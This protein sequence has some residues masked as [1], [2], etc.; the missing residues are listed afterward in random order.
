M[1]A[2]RLR[3]GHLKSVYGDTFTGGYGWAADA[4]RAKIPELKRKSITFNH[5]EQAAEQGHMRSYYRFASHYIHPTSKGLHYEIGLIRQGEVFL[6]GPSNY[7]LAEPANA[8]CG[9]MQQTTAALLMTRPNRQRIASLMA[10]Q[11]MIRE[12]SAA[13]VQAEQRI[14]KED[15][16]VL[17][18]QFKNPARREKR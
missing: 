3:C 4:V 7:G 9:S 12:A 5:V 16:E 13:F 10:L 2:L 11:N 1:E 6:S 18:G 8:S 17:A 15:S 14:V